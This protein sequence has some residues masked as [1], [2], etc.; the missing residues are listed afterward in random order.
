M[1]SET[2]LNNIRKI[3]N[4]RNITQAAMAGYMG[5]SPSFLSKILS[6]QAKLKL[7]DISNLATSLSMREIDIITYPDIYIPQNYTEK[8]ESEVTVQIK[9]KKDKRDQVLRL[10]FGDNNIEILNK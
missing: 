3:M 5:T 10:I 9:L 8:N 2:L 7:N 4:D 6:G 1:I